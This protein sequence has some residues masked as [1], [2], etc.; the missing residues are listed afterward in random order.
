LSFSFADTSCGDDEIAANA[1]E[2]AGAPCACKRTLI[3]VLNRG[4]EV[5][6][7]YTFSGL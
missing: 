5:P 1:G 2:D 7:R 4:V 3:E 6:F